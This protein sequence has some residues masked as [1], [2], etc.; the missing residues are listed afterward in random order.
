MDGMLKFSSAPDFEMPRSAAMS[1]TNTNTY[2]VTVMASAGGEMTT[3]PDVTV[4]V[5]NVPEDGT[6]TLNP[7]RP[8]VGMAR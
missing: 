6:V 7:T 8:S 1:A 4:T 3:I 5:T 2:M